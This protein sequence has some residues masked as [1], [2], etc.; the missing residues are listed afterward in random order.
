LFRFAGIN[1]YLH[2]SWFLLAL[3]GIQ[4]RMADY[5][6]YLWPALEYVA[7]FGIVTLHEFGHA[8]ACKQVGGRADQI[9]LWPFGGVAYVAPPRRPGATLWCI[10]AGPLV[11]VVLLPIV[12]A[13][14]F[15]ARRMGWPHVA[16]DAYHFTVALWWIDVGLLLFNMLPIYPLDGGQ[17]FQSLLWFVFGYARSLMIAASLGLVGVAGLI[18]LAISI[19]AWWLGVMCV[20]VVLYCWSGLQRARALARLAAAPK[21]PGLACPACREAPPLGAFWVCGRCRQ[22]FDVFASGAVCPS[23]GAQIPVVPCVACGTASPIQAFQTEPTLPQNA[24]V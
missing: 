21:H 19:Q 14:V 1:V 5:S 8:L 13:S 24:A 3:Y 11:N 7:L 4:S 15:L 20:L 17:I 10:A 23:C 6:S 2:W 22:R 12:T 16:P 18:L 9:V